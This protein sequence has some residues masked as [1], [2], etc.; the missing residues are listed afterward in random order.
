MD[1]E[2]LELLNK[3][4]YL[5]YFQDSHH[6][7]T[8]FASKNYDIN[9]YEI[10]TK[11]QRD[12]LAKKLTNLSYKWTRGNI[13]SSIDLDHKIVFPKF[14]YREFY[15]KKEISKIE[16]KDIII[17]TPTLLAVHLLLNHEDPKELLI[18]LIHKQPINYNK[19]I[20]LLPDYKELMIEVGVLQSKLLKQ[21]PLIYRQELDTTF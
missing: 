19:I 6:F 2:L 9:D 8:I 16:K 13:L 17:L 7:L 21:S 3:D 1:K 20:K 18:D 12:Y 14:R 11:I 4:D 10:T 5:F 15:P